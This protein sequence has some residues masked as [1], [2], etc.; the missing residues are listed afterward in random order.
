MQASETKEWN[1]KLKK[2]KLASDMRAAFIIA[3]HRRIVQSD[4]YLS[5]ED[6]DRLLSEMAKLYGE[7]KENE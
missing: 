2:V 3:Q 6:K 5:Q 4:K 1:E 7:S